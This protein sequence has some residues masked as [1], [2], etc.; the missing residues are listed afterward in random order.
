LEL[1]ESPNRVHAVE[2]ILDMPW[3]DVEVLDD[4]VLFS[5]V[6]FEDAVTL[7]APPWVVALALLVEGLI[8]SMSHS[9]AV[10]KGNRAFV[11][12]FLERR[13][14]NRAQWL[15]SYPCFDDR[16]VDGVQMTEG[17]NRCAHDGLRL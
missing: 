4:D 3:V 12:R 5:D 15:A 8:V 17:V 14:W 16:R 11:E 1:L 7:V 9:G 6:L 13:P 10:D 2:V